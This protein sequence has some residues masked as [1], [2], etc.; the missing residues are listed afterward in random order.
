MGPGRTSL[1]VA[2][3][4][5]LLAA[6]SCPAKTGDCEHESSE[7]CLW[8]R[9]VVGTGAEAGEADDDG[10]QTADSS[11]GTST[12]LDELDVALL[13]MIDIMQAG[14]EWSLVDTRARALCRGRD[15]EGELVDIPVTYVD[16]SREIW[17]CPIASIDFDGRSFELEAS[18]GVISLSAS[19]LDASASEE[20]STRAR[21]RFEGWCAAE[22]EELEGAKREVFHRCPLPEGPYFVIARFPRDLEASEWQVSIA[23]VDAG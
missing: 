22:F 21:E 6:A 13:T 23:V 8:E 20:L 4:A 19:N 14:I 18:Q 16:E 5:P 9:G 10:T 7:R 11:H 12:E 3:A 2:L 17:T 15:V 1:L